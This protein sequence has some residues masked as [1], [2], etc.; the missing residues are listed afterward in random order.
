LKEVD[1][2]VIR[3][4]SRMIVVSY[5]TITSA[6]HVAAVMGAANIILC[7]HDCGTLNGNSRFSGYNEALMGDRRYRDWL[8]EI[9]PQ[10][11]AVRKRIRAVFGC[12]V[13]TLS[14][15]IGIDPE[16]WEFDD[17]K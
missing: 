15:F 11:M 4:D 2:S 9:L 5:S 17:Q 7:G 12:N 10:T 6:M 16:D 13:Y 1:L 8:K 14:P 3:E